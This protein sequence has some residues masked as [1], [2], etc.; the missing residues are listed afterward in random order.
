MKRKLM[1]QLI[2][3]KNK[4]NKLPLLLY[5]AR[6]TG[7]TYL[8]KEF[9]SE[10]YDNVVYIN[11]EGEKKLSA[12][13]EF[14]I[15]PKDILRDICKL[16][17]VE[18]IPGRTLLIFDEIQANEKALTS[19]KY[20]AEQMPEQDIVA[21]GSLLGIVVHRTKFSFPVGKVAFLKMYPLDFEEF[22]WARGEEF[23]A[24]RIR[25][26]FRDNKPLPVLLHEQLLLLYE[27]YLLVGGMPAVVQSFL[28]NGDY[29]EM[30]GLIY[31]SYIADMAKYTDPSETLKIAAVYDSLPAQ[32]A[33]ENKK[34]Q[35][36]VIKSGARSNQYAVAIDWLIH[37]SIVLP[38]YLTTG[39]KRPLCVSDV[40]GSF[41]LYY[42]DVG[43]LAYRSN[44]NRE[45]LQTSE[46]FRGAVA[47]NYVA[48]A[49]MSNG[50]ELRYWTSESIAEVDF[51]LEKGN[52]VLPVEVKSGIH[53]RSKSLDVFRKR[54]GIPKVI[55]VSAKNFGLEKGIKSVPLYAA[56]CI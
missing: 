20:F 35:Y 31:N 46:E 25:E 19:L 43:I 33:K 7:K 10:H 39:G 56:F 4:K 30:Q 53:T 16:Y 6:Q 26:C 13:L 37:A 51:F 14:S 42:S 32:L 5:G 34:F 1:E 38:C 24:E 54:Y 9:G 17:H 55:R 47:E 3:W 21:A 50:Y 22:L 44:L 23:L 11:F 8:L 27:D 41:K 45:I 2:G 48:M 49:L 40:V 36:K 28:D 18:V 15:N 29:R 12:S 52:D